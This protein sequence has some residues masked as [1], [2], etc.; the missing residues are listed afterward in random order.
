MDLLADVGGRPGLDCKGFCSYC[1]FKGVKQ[2]EP[3][4]CK[5]CMPFQK[6]CDYCS[7]AIM[8]GYSGF[9]PLSMVAMELAQKSYGTR[10]KK[11]T[12]SGG[13]DLSCYPE[14]LALSQMVGQ[15][16]L[17]ITL[18]YTSGKG[19]SRGDEAAPLID[20]GVREVNFTVFS[21][22]PEIRHRYMK[23]PHP[24]AALA[25]L[26]QFSESCDVY[27]AAVLIPGVNDSIELER[28]CNDLEEMGAKGLLLMRFA[29]SR[30]QG[31][32]LGNA[33]LMPGVVPHTVE[34]FRE[35]VTAANRDYPFRVSGTPLWDPET[36]A[37]FAL[38]WKEEALSRLAPLRKGA[39]IITGAV[40]A[41]LLQKIFSA[42]GPQVNVV[43]VKKEIGCL[44]TIEDLDELDLSEV[45]ETAILPGRIMAHDM[46]VRRALT[47]DGVDRLIRRG[48]DQL[49][50]D[51]EMSISMTPEEVLDWEVEA[52]DE[53]IEMINAL[54]V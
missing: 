26:R 43:A 45:K 14:L 31:L 52:F 47:R 2:V 17:P 7:R 19:F 13:G 11:V 32:I 34:E 1:Y 27:A 53:L 44:I 12:I 33:P 4:G 22:N 46:D 39:T 5:Y 28:T 16:E 23:D 29:N 9:K 18:G 54:G 41:P 25:N 8:E 10:P 51:G 15:R 37:P 36:K 38:A 24:E 6:G 48:P 3:F 21:T 20:A 35:I 49:T 40:A 30:E 50:V 42:I